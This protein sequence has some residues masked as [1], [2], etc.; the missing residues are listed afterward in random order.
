MKSFRIVMQVLR[1]QFGQRKL[2]SFGNDVLEAW[3]KMEK[4]ETSSRARESENWL[5]AGVWKPKDSGTEEAARNRQAKELS[6]LGQ[7]LPYVQ[8]GLAFSG[9]SDCLFRRF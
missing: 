4:H 6:R 3:L 5:F 8:A 1:K 7:L 9:D 2:R